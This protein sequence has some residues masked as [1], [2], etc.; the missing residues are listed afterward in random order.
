MRLRVLSVDGQPINAAQAIL[1]NVLRDVDA[2]P[3]VGLPFT[4]PLYMLGLAATALND[5][6]QRLGDLAAGTIVVVEHR[7]SLGE[8]A[9]A[10]DAE[11]LRFAAQLPV[12]YVIRRSMAHALSVYVSR[13]TLFSPARRREIARLLA[14]PL[15]E[16]FGLPP[17]TDP[18]LL[19]RALYE[20][21]FIAD[22][23]ASEEA[24]ALA[25]AEAGEP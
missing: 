20:R 2:L 3:I 17:T 19:L 11:V 8:L 12:G 14:E 6:F 5:R 16:R 9:P 18:D 24:R 25:V 22:R 15:G 10:G 13:R 21:A 1:R 23:R 7:S 4:M